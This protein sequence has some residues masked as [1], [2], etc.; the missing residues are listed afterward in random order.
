M[1]ISDRIDVAVLGPGADADVLSEAAG[2]LLPLING[3]WVTQAIAV[4][5]ELGIADLLADGAKGPEQL[6]GR[7]GADPDAL[8][9]VLRFLASCGVFKEDSAGRFDLTPTAGL[10]QSDVAGSL[11]AFA[12]LS[13]GSWYRVTQD[14]LH[15]VRTGRSAFEHLHDKQYF[16]WLAG[17]PV[18]AE[19]FDQAMG[20][21]AAAL[22]MPTL[23][24]Y[25]WSAVATL[26]DVGG[27]NGV[28]LAELLTAFPHLRG[29]LFDLPHALN[30]AVEQFTAKG[31]SDRAE[32]LGG[33]FFDVLPP[34]ADR[35]LLSVVLHDWSD[36][37]CVRIL[38]SCHQAMAPDA[39]LLVLDT[40]IPAGNA[41]HPG[42]LVDLQMLVMLAGRERTAGEWR[43]LLAAGGFRCDEVKES[44]LFTLIEA[45]PA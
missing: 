6:A 14:I 22:R 35:Y 2:T 32:V 38:A 37:D 21:R 11:R 39:R 4:A 24:A 18:E 10:L 8:H 29:K 7:S 15:S 5:A 3:Y 44:Q 43:R 33:D 36:E 1:D 23:L 28:I 40:V 19:L 20:G 26:V 16:E 13:G 31:L 27:G 41:P 30:R 12:R 17:H 9:R 45:T 34:G 25:D 42:K